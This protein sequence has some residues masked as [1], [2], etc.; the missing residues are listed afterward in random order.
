AT[1]PTPSLHDAL[2]IFLIFHLIGQVMVLGKRS[3]TE[4]P[5]VVRVAGIACGLAILQLVVAGAIIGMK[6][7]PVVRSVHQAVGV[8]IWISTR[9][10]EHTSELQSLRHL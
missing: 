2:P 7:P 5:I 6:L 4:A 8:S 10:E 3:A 9:S 1:C